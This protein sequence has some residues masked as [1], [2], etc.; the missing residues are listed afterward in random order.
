MLPVLIAQTVL[1]AVIL[2]CAVWLGIVRWE[3]YR[4]LKE[5]NQRLLPKELNPLDQQLLTYMAEH[6]RITTV[7]FDKERPLM[8]AI[9]LCFVLLAV[10]TILNKE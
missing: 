1:A 6:A 4:S 7:A 10:V 3:E 8:T 2:L 9:L 5:L